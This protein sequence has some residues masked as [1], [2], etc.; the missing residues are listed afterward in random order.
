[1]GEKNVHPHFPFSPSF[2]GEKVAGGRMRGSLGRSQNPSPALRAP[3][4]RCRGARGKERPPPFS[5][6]PVLRRGE[7]GRRPDEGLFGA[8][9]TPHPPFGHPLPAAAGRGEKD[10]PSTGRRCPASGG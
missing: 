7:G 8:V 5:L 10:F 6:L 4:P 1:R 2:D 9:A 3:S